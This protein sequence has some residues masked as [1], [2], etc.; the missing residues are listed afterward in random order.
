MLGFIV[1][2]TLSMATEGVCTLE[3]DAWCLDFKIV[4]EIFNVIFT[5]VFALEA[6]VKI[7][8]LGPAEYCKAAMNMFDLVVVAASIAELPGTIQVLH[9]Y[10]APLEASWEFETV[11]LETQVPDVF[12]S[13]ETLEALTHSK[14]LRTDAD[15]LIVNPMRYYACGS[16]GFMSVMRAFRLVDPP[17]FLPRNPEI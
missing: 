13:G 9:C 7:A 14:A 10:M 8:G 17:P 4:V 15:T 1:L 12:L 3:L 11:R 16:G 5:F 2:N 6:M